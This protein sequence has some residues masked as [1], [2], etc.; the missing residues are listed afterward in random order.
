MDMTNSF[1]LSLTSNVY[2][3]LFLYVNEMNGI[4]GI[5]NTVAYY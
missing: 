1:Y 3:F 2:F 4:M 5:L